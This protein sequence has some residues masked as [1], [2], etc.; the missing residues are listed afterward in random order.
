M[1]R[2]RDLSFEALCEVCGLDFEHLTANERGRTNAALKQLRDLE[3][4]FD[5]DL[6]ARAIRGH[7]AAYRTAY[8]G[9]P[10][11][12]TALAAN[13]SIVIRLA[14]EKAALRVQSNAS[15]SGTGCPECHGDKWID[16]GEDDR[17]YP[18]ARPCSTCNPEGGG[19]V[20]HE[21]R[22]DPPVP[23][24][25]T[26]GRPDPVAGQVTC[27]LCGGEIHEHEWPSMYSQWVGWYP[28]QGRAGGGAHSKGK[29]PMKTAARAH[30]HCAEMAHQGRLKQ[31]NLFDQLVLSPGVVP[32]RKEQE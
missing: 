10:V 5:D 27:V 23:R 30:G 14:Q 4:S 15:A 3:A 28:E 8:P 24:S 2:Q 12:P 16:A 22:V 13:W 20:S 18:V 19:R 7:A 25:R 6:L 9:I 29:A 26:R 32:D 1:T 11:T 17:G 31:E 21:P